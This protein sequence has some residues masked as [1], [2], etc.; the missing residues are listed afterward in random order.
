MHPSTSLPLP[1]RDYNN[2]TVVREV[3]DSLRNLVIKIENRELRL[4]R[5]DVVSP[6]RTRFPFIDDDD[7]DDDA[8]ATQGF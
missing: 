6:L 7:D 8:P 3:A 1:A 5:G 4:G 2:A